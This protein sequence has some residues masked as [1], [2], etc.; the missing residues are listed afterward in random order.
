MATSTLASE[1]TRA[2]L[3]PLRPAALAVTLCLSSLG[4]HAA[5]PRYQV[6]ELPVSGWHLDPNI[7]TVPVGINRAGTVLMMTT[8]PWGSG[9]DRC[10]RHGT[11]TGVPALWVPH[12]PTLHAVAINN[13]GHVAATSPDV[14][15]R[16][17][18]M[19][20]TGDAEPI[21]IPGLGDDDCDGCRNNGQ[22]A[23][24][25]NRGQVV[26]TAWGADGRARL[27]LACASGP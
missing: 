6:I 13:A 8:S 14:V 23:D 22:A 25:N 16:T 20:W 27:C 1:S 5:A 19:L 4:A 11:C 26:G 17:H 10:D 7:D 12:R 9:A 18:A 2:I 3:P 24:L 15:E 21:G